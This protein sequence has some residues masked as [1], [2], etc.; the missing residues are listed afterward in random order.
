MKRIIIIVEG[1]TEERFVRKV[2]HPHFINLGIHLEPEQWI[3][4]R[5]TGDSGGGSNFDLVENHI[6]RRISRYS[7]DSDTFLTTMIDL[8][9]FP[10][11]GRTVYDDEVKAATR[12]VN[13]K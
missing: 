7:K 5:K 9:A 13:R 6:R 10:L 1:I 12:G 11:G 2:L 4:N 3:T 8:Y